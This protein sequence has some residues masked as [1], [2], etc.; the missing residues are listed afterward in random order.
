MTHPA[1]PDNILG[2]LLRHNV[3][4][5]QMLGYALSN[6]I[7]LVIVITAMQF[8]RDVMAAAGAED[9]FIASD[10]MV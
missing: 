7:G 4:L 9:S 3:S 2:R 1:K 8:Y 5:G 10:Y 6:L